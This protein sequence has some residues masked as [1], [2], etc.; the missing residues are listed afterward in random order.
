[1]KKYKVPIQNIQQKLILEN[2]DPDIILHDEDEYI[3][4]INKKSLIKYKD[5]SIYGK[6]FKMKKIQIPIDS[7]QHKMI[8]ENIDS[9]IILYDENDYV[10]NNILQKS[11]IL[12]L[13]T[14]INNIK[15]NNESQKKFNINNKI[16]F[17]NDD[18]LKPPTLSEILTSKKSFKKLN[19]NLW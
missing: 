3:N 11:N 17:I 6:F 10:E 18:T 16:N 19:R 7:I 4:E 14:N 5:H 2:I 1:M 12:C 13:L 15:L 9:N 8:S